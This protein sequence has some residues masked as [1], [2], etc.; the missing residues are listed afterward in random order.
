MSALETV[1]RTALTGRSADGPNRDVIVTLG[2]KKALVRW[3]P[4]GWPKQVEEAL[5]A[6]PRPDVV[7]APR[8]SPGAREAAK[9]A[10]V[11]W[12]DESGA[13]EI[14][15]ADDANTLIAV[16]TAGRP[17]APLTPVLVGGRPHSPSVKHSWPTARHPAP[18]P[19]SM[20]PGYR[21]AAR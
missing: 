16:D 20:P 3:L 4:V 9:K 8:M 10:R 15:I 14:F 19:S 11:G 17:P 7:V 2:R 21:W 13:A 18:T 12:V 1:L 5:R 6:A